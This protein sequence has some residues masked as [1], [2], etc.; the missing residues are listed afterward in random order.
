MNSPSQSNEPPSAD[1]PPRK[2]TAPPRDLLRDPLQIGI[3]IVGVTALFG[4]AGWWLDSKLNCF[5]LLMFI[6]AVLGMFGSIYSIVVRLRAQDAAAG[7][8]Q[9]R[10]S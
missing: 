9:P 4:G 1:R 6:G 5:P 10:E 2:L 8:K 3:S 7:K